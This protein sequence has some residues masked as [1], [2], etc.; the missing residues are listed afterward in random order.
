MTLNKYKN[1]HNGRR[2]FILG[3]GPSL[4]YTPLDSLT[5]EYT[6]AMNKIDKVF[7]ETDWRPTYY[8][9]IITNAEFSRLERIQNL[10]ISCF[11]RKGSHSAMEQRYSNTDNIE[12][13]DI[14]ELYASDVHVD[15]AARQDDISR[16]WSDDITEGVYRQHSSI[17]AAAQIAHYMGFDELYFLGCDLYPI[18]KPFPYMIFESGSDPQEYTYSPKKQKSRLD[19]LRTGGK[20]CRSLINAVSYKLLR[21]PRIIHSLYELYDV[22]GLTQDTHVGG[23]H[24]DWMYKV[25]ENEK[26]KRVH[27]AI[28]I[29]GEKKGFN[30]YNATLGGRLEVYKRVDL[31]EAIHK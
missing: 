31:S 18:F 2:L 3:N 4:E 22:F 14:T 6:L 8:L 1:I 11:F 10:G 24:H 19:F 12:F 7:S 13:L 25:G 21:S 16:V 5:D 27:R 28:K 30:T 9:N 17:Y 26:E 20:P 15:I 29:M 23:N